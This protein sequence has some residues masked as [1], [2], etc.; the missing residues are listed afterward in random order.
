VLV[1]AR[2]DHNRRGRGPW[3]QV[4]KEEHLITRT[5]FVCAAALAL[6]A[7]LVALGCGS[8]RTIGGAPTSDGVTLARD[9]QPIFDASCAFVGCHAGGSPQQGLDLSEGRA[10]ASTVNVASTEVPTLQRVKPGDS[11]NSYLFQ[12]VSQDNPAVGDRMPQGGDR[13]EPDT[14]DLIRR[15]IDTGANP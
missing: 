9:I 1:P 6:A 12:K 3:A 4:Q 7:C 13:L 10:H 2:P 8:G 14:L 11:A 5:R 15:W